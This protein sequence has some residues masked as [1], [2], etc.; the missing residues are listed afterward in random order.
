MKRIL[1]I[2]LFTQLC[3]VAEA[4]NSMVTYAS[5]ET[6]Y[7]KPGDIRLHTNYFFNPITEAEF[8]NK[9]FLTADGRCPGRTFRTGFEM[10]GYYPSG[11]MMSSVSMYSAVGNLR[12]NCNYYFDA[13]GQ[14]QD[15]SITI[16]K[17]K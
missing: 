16:S 7:P 14:L 5:S 11:G 12:F 8:Y 13:D 4:Q 6:S 15:G 10:P 9:S 2:P 3:F 17:K 1:L